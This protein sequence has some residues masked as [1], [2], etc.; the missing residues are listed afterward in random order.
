MLIY[1]E[2]APRLEWSSFSGIA[3]TNFL[4][5]NILDRN[6][7]KKRERKADKGA[8]IILQ[9]A[10][11]CSCRIFFTGSNGIHRFVELIDLQ[12]EIFKQT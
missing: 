11:S 12:R 2:Y 8:Q 10:V 5:L 1:V 7:R 3:T 4:L 6:D 9:L